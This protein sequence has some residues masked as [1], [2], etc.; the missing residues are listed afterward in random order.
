VMVDSSVVSTDAKLKF[1]LHVQQVF[2]CFH[3]NL[4]LQKIPEVRY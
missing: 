1:L 4:H 2:W 3:E